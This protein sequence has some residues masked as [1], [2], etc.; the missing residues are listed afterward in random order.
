MII[1]GKNNTMLCECDLA[2]T[3]L[4]QMTGLMFAKTLKNILFIFAFD[5]SHA[6]HALF[7]PYKFHAVYLDKSKKVVDVQVIK[8]WTWITKSRKPARFLLEISKG[9]IPK[10]GDYLCWDG[11]S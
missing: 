5:G 1:K 10:I 4:K 11:K 6:I 9:K 7:V 2:A 3:P 8:P